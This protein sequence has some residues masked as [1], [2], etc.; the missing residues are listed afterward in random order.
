MKY[1]IYLLYLIILVIVN[2]SY[3]YILNKNN[4][5]D[6][7]FFSTNKIKYKTLKYCKIFLNIVMFLYLKFVL[8]NLIN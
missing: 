8:S 1:N 3:T 5:I 4:R 7:Y 2:V 6:Y